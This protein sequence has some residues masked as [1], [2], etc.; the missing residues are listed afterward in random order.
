MNVMLL[1]DLEGIAGVTSIRFMDKTDEAYAQARRLLCHSITL[2]VQTCLDAGADTVYYVDG[3]AGGGNVMESLIDP[4]AQKCSIAQWQ[5]LL[6]EGKIDCQLELGSHARAGT[7]GGFL[8]HTI[9]SRSWFSHRINGVEMSELSM[10]ALVCGAYGVPIAACIGDEAAC[11]QARE[12]I[13]GIVTGAVK[14]ALCRNEA[15]AYDNADDILV[16]AVRRALENYPSIAPLRMEGPLTVELT[17]YRSDM[18]EEALAHCACGVI[19]LDARTLQRTVSRLTCY[20]DL[21]F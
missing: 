13:P 19:R 21:K 2:A 5:Q 18:C 20:E 9:N 16:S 6:R 3:H 8:D 15:I 4:R 17:F 7:L 1:T 11:A 10:H 14:K 12:Y